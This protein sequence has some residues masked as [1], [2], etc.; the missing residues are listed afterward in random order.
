[1]SEFEPDPHALAARLQHELTAER[2]ETARLRALIAHCEEDEDAV[3]EAI[4]RTRD[5]LDRL[6]DSDSGE[7]KAVSMTEMKNAFERTISA[8]SISR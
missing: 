3:L 7:R 8:H 6:S 1:M 5:V 4:E 2:A